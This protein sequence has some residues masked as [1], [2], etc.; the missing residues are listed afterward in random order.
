MPEK[1]RGSCDIKY[2]F[3]SLIPESCRV[4]NDAEIGQVSG[5]ES[6][7]DEVSLALRYYKG[8]LNEAG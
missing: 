8:H 2:Q 5:K 4:P 7:N 3:R 6:H 1:V